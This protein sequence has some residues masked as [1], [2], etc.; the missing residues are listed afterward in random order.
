M[1]L[2]LRDRPAGQRVAGTGRRVTSTVVLLGLVSMFTDISSES[3][4]AVLPIYLTTIL[5]M[6]AL[7]YGFV[8]GIYQ[9]VSALVRILGGWAADRTDHPKWVAFVGYFVSAASRVF[10][11]PVHSFAAITGVITVD[12]L[13]KGLRTAPRDALIAASSPAHA[14]G[15]AY[16][17]HRALDT[18]GALIGP[19]L[20]FWILFVVPGDYRSVFLASLAFAI[21]GVAM[22][23]LIVPDL[24]PRKQKT[25]TPLP[26]RVSLSHL[27]TPRLGRLLVAA[28]L[29]GVL[30][31]GDGFLYLELTERDSLATKYFPLLYVGTNVAYLVLAVPFG[32]LADRIGRA[33]V[34]IGGHVLL[35][36]AYLCAGGP[37]GGAVAS[38]GCLLLL[39]A[40]YAA[41][42]GVL[43][44]ISG[45]IV[46][47][48]I[49]ASG[50]ATAQTIVAV[51]RFVS[52]LAFGLLWTQ[53][54]RVDALLSISVLLALGIPIAA[55]LLRGIDTE[56]AIA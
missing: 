7:A 42:D 36:I 9:G 54:G 48:S 46:D 49:R 34:F 33:R 24:R 22:L 35:L 31:I 6:S 28:G 17:V 40:Y 41:T 30:T 13:G 25:A 39:G 1:Y 38:V 45:R 32:R 10:L 50:I 5:G 51:A 47:T 29:L 16:G 19:L 21:V 11:L 4:N 23:L 52:S 27:F 37:F 20:A 15:R 8:D 2:T 14:L 44:A 55:F 53:V 56:P 3:V 26:A 18:L 12:R 43:P